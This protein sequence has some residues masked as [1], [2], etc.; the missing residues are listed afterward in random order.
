MLHNLNDE[1]SKKKNKKKVGIK[2]LD[3]YQLYQM[4]KQQKLEGCDELS[5]SKVIRRGDN[6]LKGT[7]DSKNRLIKMFR[8]VVERRLLKK[9]LAFYESLYPK[10]VNCDLIVKL[11]ALKNSL[12]VMFPDNMYSNIGS[13]MTYI[14]KNVYTNGYY[15][16]MFGAEK[17]QNDKDMRKAF[18]NISG[19]Q[20]LDEKPKSSITVNEADNII[21]EEIPDLVQTDAIMDLDN[22]FVTLIDKQNFYKQIK[23]FTLGVEEYNDLEKNTI[24]EYRLIQRKQQI[25]PSPKFISFSENFMFLA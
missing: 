17:S 21:E 5:D 8:I 2:N 6:E 9:N 18:F 16:G 7:I 19:D 1:N 13:K 4:N 3:L 25:V 10:Q 11:Y 22:L 23:K 20:P 12:N 24:M 15:Y 14:H